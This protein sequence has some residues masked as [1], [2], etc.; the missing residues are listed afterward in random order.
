MIRS[1]WEDDLRRTSGDYCGTVKAVVNGPRLMTDNDLSEYTM[2]AFQ[3]EF[4]LELE[5]VFFGE[6]ECRPNRRPQRI[7]AVVEASDT[8]RPYRLSQVSSPSSCVCPDTALSDPKVSL[9]PRNRDSEKNPFL[10]VDL[11]DPNGS[12]FL[13]PSVDNRDPFL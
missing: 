2:M 12:R 3:Q 11:F 7:V 9:R 10:V 5:E 6:V 8:Y 13:N 1:V 4:E